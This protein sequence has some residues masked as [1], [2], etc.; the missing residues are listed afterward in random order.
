MEMYST[1]K[2]RTNERTNDDNSV[3]H[4]RTN[5]THLVQRR[6]VRHSFTARPLKSVSSVSQ[7][8]ESPRPHANQPTS[9][10]PPL[11]HSLTHSLTHS[12]FRP[13]HACTCIP[14]SFTHTPHESV[15]S[16][17]WPLHSLVHSLTP[18]LTH[19]YLSISKTFEIF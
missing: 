8:H 3:R 18:S 11:P 4:R 19:A 7:I 2:E 6:C 12:L 1:K 13:V 15:I 10:P 17:I 16:S 9:Q 14:H 5:V